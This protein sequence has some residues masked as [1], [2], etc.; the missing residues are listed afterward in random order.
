MRAVH[1]MISLLL[2][3]FISKVQGMVNR[4]SGEWNYQEEVAEREAEVADL[5]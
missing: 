4:N 3:M 1:K 2:D 5:L